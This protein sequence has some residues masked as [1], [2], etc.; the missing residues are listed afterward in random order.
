MAY[1]LRLLNLILCGD[2]YKFT[3]NDVMNKQDNQYYDGE[4]MFGVVSLVVNF[5]HHIFSTSFFL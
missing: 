3:N 1:Y 2:E 4:Q 5:W